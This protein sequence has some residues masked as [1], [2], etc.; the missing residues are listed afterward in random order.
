M[1]VFVWYNP[2]K[3]KYETGSRID[4]ELLGRRI[5]TDHTLKLLYRFNRLSS[6][7]AEKMVEE[8]NH[9]GKEVKNYA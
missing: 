7:L 9:S 8:L 6:Q 2:L 4:F 1:D 5:G 3:E